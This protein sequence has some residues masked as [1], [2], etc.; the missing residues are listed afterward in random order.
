MFESL[1]KRFRQ[2]AESLDVGIISTQ[3]KKQNKEKKRE[4]SN[5]Y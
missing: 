2:A 4:K 1:E 3:K 5:N